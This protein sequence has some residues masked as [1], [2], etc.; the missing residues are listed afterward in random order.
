[1]KSTISIIFILFN[2]LLIITFA[3]FIIFF[4]I[5]SIDFNKRKKFAQLIKKRLIIKTNI[6]VYLCFVV[7]FFFDSLAN[8]V[9]HHRSIVSLSQKQNITHL[10]PDDITPQSNLELNKLRIALSQNEHYLIISTTTILCTYILWRITS[11]LSSL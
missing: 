3:S 9:D 1:M 10:T 6:I 11:L 2:L 8:V 7:L 4:T 5:Q